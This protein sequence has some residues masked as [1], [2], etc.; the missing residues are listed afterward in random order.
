MKIIK[1]NPHIPNSNSIDLAVNS[2]KNG[3][4]L[5]YP[6]DTCY[7]L[8]ADI[9]NKSAFNKIYQIKK[10]NKSKPVSVIVP[11][12][13]YISNLAVVS[14]KQKIILKK[15]LP[16]P[17][18]FILLSLDENLFPFSSIGIRIPSYKTTELISKKF[19][20]PYI[21]TSANISSYPPAF[22]VKDFIN[23]LNSSDIKPD[24]ILDA[25]KLSKNNL[26]TV[27]DITNDKI[28]ILRQGIQKIA[29]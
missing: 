8:G 21:T 3:G 10:R 1:I 4:I 2:L 6:T 9:S 24:L 20:Y 25:G 28:K 18:T 27:I 19:N 14:K 5:M 26:S 7:G 12:I 23:Q 11:N 16:G 17:V 13:E 29:N 15:Y 22:E